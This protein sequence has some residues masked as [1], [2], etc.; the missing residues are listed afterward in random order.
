MNGEYIFFY[1]Y[2]DIVADPKY[3]V[4]KIFEYCG[5]PSELIEKATTN[6]MSRDSQRESPLSK[7]KYVVGKIV[8]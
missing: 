6:G 2:E 5:M 7:T 4:T 1:R 3:A 8:M